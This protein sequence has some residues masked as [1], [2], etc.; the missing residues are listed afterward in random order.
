MKKEDLDFSKV[1][2]YDVDKDGNSFFR[3]LA[4]FFI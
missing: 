2:K 1:T 3:N 4:F